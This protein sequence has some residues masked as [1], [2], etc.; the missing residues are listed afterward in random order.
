MTASITSSA[1][2]IDQQIAWTPSSAAGAATVW[3]AARTAALQQFRVVVEKLLDRMLDQGPHHRHA[4]S[5]GSPQNLP[6]DNAKQI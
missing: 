5:K 1:S 3:R 4:R 6:E 2:P